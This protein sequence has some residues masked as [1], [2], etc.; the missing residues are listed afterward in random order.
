M[1]H[2]ALERNAVSRVQADGHG[3]C[4]QEVNSVRDRVV[5]DRAA[6]FSESDVIRL[7]GR[8]QCRQ[9][10]ICLECDSIRRVRNQHRTSLQRVLECRVVAVR[11][12]DGP[13]RING[14]DEDNVARRTSIDCQAF[15]SRPGR[16]SV[17]GTEERD[18]CSRGISRHSGVNHQVATTATEGHASHETHRITGR[19]DRTR[20]RDGDESRTVLCHRTIRGDISVDRQQASIRKRDHTGTRRCHRGVDRDHITGDLNTRKCCRCHCTI[21]GRLPATRQLSETRC[22][23]ACG[24]GHIDRRG[25]NDISQ[26]G[27]TANSPREEDVACGA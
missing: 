27:V 9:S 20:F 22:R 21:K 13:K 18:I 2:A 17:Y 7:I 26:L 11:D 10:R 19:G 14:T 4:I 25:D 1:G 5:Y 12:R 15:G 6:R 8:R 3:S 24:F 23:N 16:S